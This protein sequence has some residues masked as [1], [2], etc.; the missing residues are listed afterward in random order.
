MP[1]TRS[2]W[3]RSVRAPIFAALLF[4]SCGGGSGPVLDLTVEEVPS[5]AEGWSGQPHLASSDAGVVLS[6]LETRAD[7]DGR[8]TTLV[9]DRWSGSGWAGRRTVVRSEDLLVNWADFPAVVPLDD[10]AL[11]A[12]WLVRGSGSGED[13]GMRVSVSGDGGAT[14]TDPW[15][16]HEDRSAVAHGFATIFPV[17][18]G[19]GVIWLDGRGQPGAGESEPDSTP[20]APPAT[21]A[22]P[23]RLGDVSLWFRS[24]GLPQDLPSLISPAESAGPEILLDGQTCECCQTDVSRSAEGPVLFYRDRSPEEVRDIYVLRRVGGEWEAPRPVHDDGWVF[25]A[26]PINGPAADS[27]GEEVAVAWFTA[28]D[29][30]PRVLLA[31]SDDA[32]AE[33]DAPVRIDDGN[34]SGRVDVVLLTDGTALVSW[35]ERVQG[36]AE[37]RVRRVTRSGGRSEMVPV[38]VTGGGQASG[39]PQMV[40]TSDGWILF[41]WTDSRDTESRV[42]TARARVGG[43]GEGAGNP[44]GGAP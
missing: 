36:G 8:E 22:D 14:W 29:D 44:S 33:F 17:E 41:A 11:A 37:V 6:W 9:M 19:V 24:L 30:R 15:I 10:G 25:P 27:R 18:E 20:A 3:I 39:F 1:R 34:P 43:L 42:R 13:Y 40:A 2:F 31:F 21:R 38:A 26:C 32:G 12:H 5:P 23:R 35:L 16:P 7:A 4:A 28:V